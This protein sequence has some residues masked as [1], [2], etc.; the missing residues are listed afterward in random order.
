MILVFAL[1]TS[2]SCE[3]DVNNLRYPDFKQ[4]MV[5][6]A[7]ISPDNINNYISVTSNRRIYGDLSMHETLGNLSATLS[8]NNHEIS[9]DTTG[10]G[11]VFRSSD[12]PVEEGKTFKLKISSDKGLSA[13]A[14]CT[15]PLRRS[16]SLEVDTFRRFE[17]VSD[18]YVYAAFMLNFYFTDFQGEDNYYRFYCEQTTYHSSYYYPKF[19]LRYLDLE[20]KYF[21]DKGKDGDRSLITTLNIDD[22]K[23]DDSSFLKVYLL[24]TDKAY[25]DFHKSLDK[26]EG[27]D[28][29]FTEASPV[30]SNINGGLGIFAA[31]TVDSLIFRLK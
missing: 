31:Y 12:L 19:T 2:A 10:S 14:T 8:D 22:P 30:Y 23:H 28:D 21:T 4:K 16:F 25:F 29:P 13:E 17:Q 11:F 18:D 7:F 9:L 3:R 26:Y 6:S 5:I 27:G 24:N 15:V 20:N 1:L